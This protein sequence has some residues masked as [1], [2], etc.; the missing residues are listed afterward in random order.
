[1]DYTLDKDPKF[2][3]CLY[4]SKPTRD[5]PKDDRALLHEASGWQ[6]IR[7]MKLSREFD[8]GKNKGLPF[9]IQLSTRLFFCPFAENSCVSVVPASPA[10]LPPPVASIHMYFLFYSSYSSAFA[11]SHLEREIAYERLRDRRGNFF[12]FFC[13]TLHVA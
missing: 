6:R 5:M 2:K 11:A 12:Q 8:R 7:E 4:G 10:P 3:K 1:M 13:S 9:P